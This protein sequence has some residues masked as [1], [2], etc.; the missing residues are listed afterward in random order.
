MKL[1]AHYTKQIQWIALLVL[2]FAGCSISWE[3]QNPYHS[4]N[5]AEHKQ[6]KANFHTHTTVSDGRMNPHEVVD[7]YHKLGYD[8]LAISDHNAVTYPWTGF[9]KLS[10]SRTSIERMTN[11]P[12]VMPENLHYANRDPVALGMIDIEANELSRHHHM[13]SYF[14]DHDGTKTEEASM[15]SIVRKG[16][17]AMLNHPGRYSGDYRRE[18][19]REYSLQWYVEIYTHYPELFGL[20]VYNQGNRYPQD[21]LIWDSILSITMPGRPVWGYSN[22]DMHLLS[23]LGHNWNMLILPELTHEWVRRGMENGLS[24]FVYAPQGH[25]GPNPPEISSVHVNSRK[26][27]IEIFAHNYDSIHWISGGKVLSK[28]SRVKLEDLPGAIEYIR[29][30][31]YGKA[32]TVTGTQP[33]GIV[34]NRK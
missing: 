4:V 9:S 18:H 25:E 20:E 31:L 32:E 10:P 28:M 12:E 11:M 6:Y 14:T 3:I 30:E 26:G 21:R 29:A 7:H 24:F 17:I 23:T 27:F 19:L 8:I 33:F 16:G 34:R 15:D 13:G 1:K 2:L 5:W 22:D